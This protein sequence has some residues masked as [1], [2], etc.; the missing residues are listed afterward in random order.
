[1][2][3]GCISLL[4]NVVQGQKSCIMTFMHHD[5]MHYKMFNCDFVF[6]VDMVPKTQL[7]MTYFL[8]LYRFFADVLLL[9]WRLH[10]Y[11]LPLNEDSQQV[12]YQVSCVSQRKVHGLA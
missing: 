1:M 12:S 8:L 6:Q 2:Q 5:V 3:F 9:L 7:L 11:D 4:P 10:G